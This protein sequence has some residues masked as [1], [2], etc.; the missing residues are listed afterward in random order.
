MLQRRT[1]NNDG[2]PLSSSSDIEVIA[3]SP[4]V[5][6]DVPMDVCKHACA[7]KQRSQRM[8]ANVL[9]EIRAVQRSIRRCM[10]N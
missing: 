8:A 3:V 2:T 1:P 4:E 7:I 10:R 5:A 9:I 6:T